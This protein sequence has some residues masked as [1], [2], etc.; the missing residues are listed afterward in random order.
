MSTIYI[1]FGDP[2]DGNIVPLESIHQEKIEMAK[3]ELNT[4]VNAIRGQVDKAVFRKVRGQTILGRKPTHDGEPTPAQAAHQ[5]RFLQAIEFG[6]SVMEDTALRVRYEAVAA[7]RD[8]PVMAVCIKDFFNPPQVLSIDA[9]AYNGQPG[10]MITI[11]TR[12]DF[13]LAKVVVALIDTESSSPLE[14][15]TAFETSPGSNKWIYTA[16]TPFTG[17][18]VNVQV[19]ATDFPGGITVRNE[20]KPLAAA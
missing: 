6:R 13:G 8:V 11:K 14:T 2:N 20:I 5:E 16:R 9:G 19:T 4:M 7:E 1:S 17:S 12:D 15:G 10:D 3:I 18:T